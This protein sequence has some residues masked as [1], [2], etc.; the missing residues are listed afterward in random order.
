M[1]RWVRLLLRDA[2][3]V[4]RPLGGWSVPVRYTHRCAGTDP[5]IL[6]GS[7][8]DHLPPLQVISPEAFE[9]SLPALWQPHYANPYLSRKT[10]RPMIEKEGVLR[11]QPSGRYASADLVKSRSRSLPASPSASRWTDGAKELQLIRMEYRHLRRGG[12]EYFSVDAY[13]LRDGL[14]AA[15]GEQG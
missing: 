13:Q 4:L 6:L 12:G 11:M 7:R 8:V 2:S 1:P 10:E 3:A 14:R 9:S 5:S 15:V